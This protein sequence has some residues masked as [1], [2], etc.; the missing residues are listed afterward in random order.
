MSVIFGVMW[1]RAYVPA[2]RR[3][4]EDFPWLFGAFR[5]NRRVGGGVLD[6]VSAGARIADWN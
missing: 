6:A 2:G 4:K 5:V 1:L 3:K